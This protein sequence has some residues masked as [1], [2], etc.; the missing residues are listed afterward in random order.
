MRKPKGGVSEV[1]L[2]AGSAL[3]LSGGVEVED[4]KGDP[5]LDHGANPSVDCDE[6]PRRESQR[7]GS[8]RCCVACV[9]C[10]EH[11]C[12]TETAGRLAVC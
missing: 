6:L 12:T 2:R 10:W 1:R 8:I 11:S 7:T 9:E 3:E 4:D 5:T